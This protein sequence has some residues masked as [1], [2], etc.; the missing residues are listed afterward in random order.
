MV[1]HGLQKMT[2]LDF[3]GKVATTLFTGGCNLRC[4]FCH[5]AFLVTRIDNSSVYSEEEILKFL[6]TRTGLLDGICITG[7]E[8]L[9]Q[10]DIASF[11][12]KVKDMGFALKLDTN[13]CY[14][15][16]LKSLIDEGLLDY[17]AMDI[18]NS[19]EKYAKTV[20]IPELDLTP[21]EKSV[22]ILKEKKVNYEFRTTVIKEFHELE[23]FSEIGEWI[24]GADRYFLQG[25]TD[26]GNL[27][28]E[29]MNPVSKKEMEKMRD[30]ASKYVPFC[31]IRGVD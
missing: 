12:K 16:K 7:G 19:K 15:D 20:G 8:P 5:N 31:E 6:G 30:L 9:M 21:I 11:I 29:N 18:K 4:P 3:P 25:F 26:S 17:V 10:N 14:P 2:L 23:D 27:I 28:G 24:K 1:F 22:E 13:G